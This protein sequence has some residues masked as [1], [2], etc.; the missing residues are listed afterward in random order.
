M[1]GSGWELPGPNPRLWEG[2]RGSV[3]AENLLPGL[4][5]HCP[6]HWPSHSLTSGLFFICKKGLV[7]HTTQSCHLKL[8]LR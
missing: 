8:K 4:R 3:R 2:D 5:S 6:G 7:I 1:S